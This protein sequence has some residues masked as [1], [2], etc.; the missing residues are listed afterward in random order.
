MSEHK[1]VDFTWGSSAQGVTHLQ[2]PSTPASL[3][4]IRHFVVEIAQKLGFD[5][6]EIA[7]IEMAVGE[8]CTNIIEH[9]YQTQPLRDQIEVVIETFPNRMEV[10]LLDYSTVN[11][12]VDEAPSLPIDEYLDTQRKRGLGLYI[13][14]NFVDTI[15][16]RF[17]CGQ[18]NQ[19]RMV[20]FLV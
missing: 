1:D 7:K 13:I 17:V 3:P 18:G 15:E 11:F 8:A 19:L 12:P 6:D 5:E 9:A 16:H 4:R 14:R 20:K 10:T 2:L